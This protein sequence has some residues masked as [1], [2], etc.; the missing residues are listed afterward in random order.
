[1]LR[2]LRL[3]GQLGFLRLFGLLL[4]RLRTLGQ[5]GLLY[6]RIDAAHQTFI[7]RFAAECGQCVDRVGQVAILT[8][9]GDTL[10][11]GLAHEIHVAL[12]TGVVGGFKFLVRVLELVQ[13][14]VGTDKRQFGLCVGHLQVADDVGDDG[15]F[16]A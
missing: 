6:V 14:F 9:E 3:F 5:E 4:L 13:P 8:V 11:L 16:F 12:R 1:M 7:G 2:F 15:R 10:L